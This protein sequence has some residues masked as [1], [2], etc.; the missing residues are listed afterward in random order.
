MP[1]L[2]YHIALAQ[3][4]AEAL[5]HPLLRQYPGAFLLGATA[6]DIRSMTRVEREETHFAPLTSQEVTA[7]VRGLL[8]AYPSLRRPSLLS[9]PTQAFLLGY[10]SHLIADMAWVLWVFRPYFANTTLFPEPVEGLVLDRALQLALDGR[11]HPRVQGLAPLLQGGE[12]GVEVGFLSP[13]DLARWREIVQEVCGRPFSW[14]RLRRFTRRLFPNGDP[15]AHRLTEEVIRDPSAA[16][17]RLAARVPPGEV[18]R[19]TRG[20]Q[21]V[22]LSV[23]KEWLACGL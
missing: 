10:F 12:E 8:E 13:G 16:L 20:C 23:A 2:I 1:N 5:P 22:W 3:E 11:V 15:L 19:F 9:P 17:D 18:D 4:G 6:P 21:E 14:E 7:G